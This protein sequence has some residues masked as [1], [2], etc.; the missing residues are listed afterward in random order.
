MSGSLLLFTPPSS[1]SP[2]LLPS[3][4]LLFSLPTALGEETAGGLTGVAS[5]PNHR[6]PPRARATAGAGAADHHERARPRARGGE[7]AVG[8][9]QR[10]AGRPPAPSAVTEPPKINPDYHLSRATWLISDNQEL[11]C[12]LCRVMPGKSLS[13]DRDMS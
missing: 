6:Q 5:G 2:T 10:A 13:Q 12:R 4:A 1:P 9:Q 3:C 8:H 7:T 11:F